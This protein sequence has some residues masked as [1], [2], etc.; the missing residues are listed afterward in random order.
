MRSI[1]L[2]VVITLTFF[3]ALAQNKKV[4]DS[5]ELR[6]D[7]LNGLDR[8]RGLYELVYYYLR[9]DTRKAK[10]Y[11]LETKKFNTSKDNSILAYT[12]MA[13]GIYYNRTGLLDSAVLLLEQSKNL[14]TISNDNYVVVRVL[15]S[16]AHT[17]ISS[18]KAEKGLDNLFQALRVVNDDKEMELK[19]RTN[20]PWAY[21]ELKQYRKCVDFGLQN[22]RLMEGTPFEWIALYTYN[23]VAVSY[24]ALG[25]LDSAKYF[26]D[27]GIVAAQKGNDN[28]S[29]ANAYFILGTIYSNAG[30]NHLAIE[31]YLKARP[32]R[33][34]VG[35]PFFI[36]SDL[37]SISEL[38]YKLGDYKKGVEAGKE[39]LAL[40]EKFNLSLKFE[41][42]YLSLAKNYEGLSDY[43]NSSKY[44]RL[45]AVAKDTL[46]KNASSEAIA[47]M[48]TKYETEKKE[49]QLAVQKAELFEQKAQI[50]Q[51]NWIMSALAGSIVLM[52]IIFF[53]LRS[54][55]KRKQLI[56]QKE[57]ELN[58]R[59]AQ[60]QASIESQENERKRFA[61]DLHDGMGQLIS[62][63]RL[64]INNVN[65]QSSLQ[66]RI[67]VV[68][69]SETILNEMH[70]EIRSIAFNLM[71]QTLVQHGLV[72][73]LQEMSDRLNG[74]GKIIVRVTAFDMPERLNE[75][76]E[77]SLY[78]VIQE[79]VN[80]VI[81][82]ASATQIQ[83]QLI[84]H[85]TEF[86]VIVEDDGAGFD[87][88]VLE[89]GAGNGWKNIKSRL[90]LVKA[91]IEIDSR[92]GMRG[93]TVIIHI[94]KTYSDIGSSAEDKATKD[95]KQAVVS[96]NTQ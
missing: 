74:A 72:P 7:K 42:T 49:K 65:Q 67:D 90:N 55:Y 62:A 88:S 93:T 77:I 36:V 96:A 20:I 27:K 11:F 29:L 22:I 14:A 39:A 37:Y 45:Y 92:S 21:L 57:Q 35:S 18:G 86:D 8:A 60:I 82:Y 23:N 78:R 24:G 40:A 53:L 66:D 91:T 15:A 69:K 63:L 83:V 43:K 95:L 70:R 85:E 17:F 51:T 32:F 84:A 64:S 79:W 6:I 54:R 38:Y 3:S 19:L 81:K 4:A 80:N 50:Q 48:E 13:Q 31:Q 41:G 33:E 16:L 75:L 26:I 61:Q 58:I 73:A 59:E 25:L 2:L 94:P 47:E 10:Q 89:T 46:Y 56:L 12:Y 44:Y 68:G 87:L 34:K 9:V 1:S 30:K 76:A 71:P 5:I 28:Q 52:A